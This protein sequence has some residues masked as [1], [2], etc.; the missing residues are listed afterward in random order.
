MP[1]GRK[2]W[3]HAS[4]TGRG[5]TEEREIVERERVRRG[6]GFSQQCIPC[7]ARGGPGLLAA[8]MGNLLFV[9]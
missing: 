7:S 8:V 3:H 6:G 4:Q 1:G 2:R 5:A 9:C